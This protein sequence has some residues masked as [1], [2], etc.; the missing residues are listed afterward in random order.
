MWRYCVLILVTSIHIL[1]IGFVY[2]LIYPA[3]IYLFKVNNRNTRK[4]CEICLKLAIK[5]QNSWIAPIVCFYLCIEGIECPGEYETKNP[6]VWYN[7]L[8][9]RWIVIDNAL[10]T[11]LFCNCRLFWNCPLLKDIA[12]IFGINNPRDFLKFWNCTRFTRA[13]S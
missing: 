12:A 5:T 13:I 2:Y 1:L 3:H 11:V 10:L 9:T 4:R 8:I 6:H 7:E